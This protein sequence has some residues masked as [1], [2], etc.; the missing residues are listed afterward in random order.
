MWLLIGEV[1]ARYRCMPVRG[2]RRPRAVGSMLGY[3]LGFAL[4]SL[5]CTVGPFLAVTATRGP[6]AV[7]A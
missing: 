2:G 3:G 7:L 6:R 5:S 1:A 4:A